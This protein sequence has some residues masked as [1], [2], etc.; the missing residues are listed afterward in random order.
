[1][2]AACA[3]VAHLLVQLGIAALRGL[4]LSFPGR[5]L[6][7]QGLDSLLGRLL[8]P[9]RRRHPLVAAAAVQAKRPCRL[10]VATCM[11]LLLQPH[12]AQHPLH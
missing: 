9:L 1:M 8:S 4:Q 7:L 12:C 10:S 5:F 2:V 3:V 11:S 6:A